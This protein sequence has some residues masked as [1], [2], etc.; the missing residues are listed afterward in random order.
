MKTLELLNE[1]KAKNIDMNVIFNT[2]IQNS[3]TTITNN[4]KNIFNDLTKDGKY[5]LEV[6]AGLQ[7]KTLGKLEEQ[8]GTLQDTVATSL[9]SVE[10]KLNYLIRV[11]EI[12]QGALGDYA[13]PVL[14]YEAFKKQQVPPTA[15]VGGGSTIVPS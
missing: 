14:T 6:I 15:T 9:D 8:Q 1:V 7:E 11:A 10:L 4:T 3:V 2:E 5:D 13:S 12:L